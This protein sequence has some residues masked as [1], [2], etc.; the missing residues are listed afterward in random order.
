MSFKKQFFRNIFISGGYTFSVQIIGFIA[1]FITSRLL[2]PADFGLVGLIAVF[3]NFISIFSDGGISYAVI[4]SKYQDTYYRGLNNVSVIIGIILCAA[5]IAI[6][7]PVAVFYKNYDLILPGIFISFLF[8]ARSVNIVPI[9][10]LQ[11]KLQFAV[12]GRAAL[13]GALLATIST[14]IMAFAGLKYWSLV[15]SQFIASFTTTFLLYRKTGFKN[16]IAPKAVVIKSFRLAK[17]L[18]GSLMAFNMVN[19]WTRNSDN[20]I[21]GKYYGT[22]DLGIY[23]RAYLLLWMPLTLIAGIFSSVLYPSLIKHK[24]EGGNTQ[25]EYYFMLKIISLINIPVALILILFPHPFVEILWG[26][27]WIALAKLLP[28]FGLLIMTQTLTSTIGSVMIMENEEKAMIHSGWVNVFMIGGIIYGAT[29]SLTAIAAFYALSY[30][31][32]VLPFNIFYIMGYKLRYNAGLLAFWLPKLFLSIL[33]WAAIYYAIPQLLLA[34]LVLWLAI[35]FWDTRKELSKIASFLT[36]RSSKLF[37][38]NA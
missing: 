24:N 29:I 35:V 21:V 16:F 31:I 15:W 37:S 11:K 14:I 3:S 22:N 30:L 2:L 26:E 32:I 27:N 38:K 17:R 1:T 12:A 28:Y 10:V 4:R 6:I 9:A 5:F 7:Y 25:K 19:Y 20:L 23:N 36:I 33:L 13:I 18:I 8:I 34:G